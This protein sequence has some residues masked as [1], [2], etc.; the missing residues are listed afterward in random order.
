[1]RKGYPL[2]II[3]KNDRSKYYR[4]LS[5][6]DE[7]NPAPLVRFVAQALERSL[8]FYLEA[9]TPISKKREKFLSLKEISQNTPYSA[10]YLNLLA[11]EGKL[12][13]HKKGHKSKS[14][15]DELVRTLK[16]WQILFQEYPFA[17]NI[18]GKR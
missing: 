2:T 18:A 14:I 10:K 15:I 7:G 12:E 6:A 13:A 16:N 9:L 8:D 4:V 17:V 3:L 11:R 1:M 5:Q